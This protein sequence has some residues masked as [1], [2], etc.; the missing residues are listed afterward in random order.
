MKKKHQHETPCRLLIHR[1]VLEFIE[2]ESAIAVRTETGGVLA[3]FGDLTAGEVHVTHAS[4]PG[5]RARKTMF[6]FARDTEY[7]QEFL[8]SVARQSGGAIDYLGEW[9]KHHE[10]APRPSGQDVTT[11]EKIALSSNYHVSECLLLIVGQ[12]NSRSSL[13]AF[14]VDSSGASMRTNWELCTVCDSL[15]PGAQII[16]DRGSNFQS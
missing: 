12:S 7:C 5:P 11:S 6:S 3:G 14:F 4:R 15:L 13:R 1:S 16:Y 10:H 2:T 9:H 8:D